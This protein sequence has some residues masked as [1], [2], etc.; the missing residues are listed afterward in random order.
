MH[1]QLKVENYKMW[2]FTPVYACSL[3]YAFTVLY[4]VIKGGLSPAAAA[5]YH[6]MYDGFK[7]GVQDCSFAFLWGMLV[8]WYVGI[9]FANRTVH[10]AIVT[11]ASRTAIVISR[12]AAISV[13]TILF[14]IVTIIGEVILYGTKFGFS[15]EGFNPRD[16]LWIL[17][18]FLQ[19]IAFD[20]FFVLV[21]YICG[22]VYSALV[23]SVLI[24]TIG[25][26]ILRNFLGGNP[27]YEHSFFCFAKSSE[28]SDLIP[29]AICA[30]I[31]IVVLV[32]GTVVIFNRKDV[33]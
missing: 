4:M 3:F 10:R 33:N 20:A 19:L 12:L 32:A 2:R 31:A 1:N 9:D 26:N 24:A 29:C 17:V 13:L 7:E 14:H 8:A 11:G 25:G 28:N 16:I 5:M 18:V 27:I 6:N 15:L 22:N 21:T 23:T 30:I